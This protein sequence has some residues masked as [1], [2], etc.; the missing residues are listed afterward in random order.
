MGLLAT[1]IFTTSALGQNTASISLGWSPSPDPAVVGYNLYSGAASQTYTNLVSVGNVTNAVMGSLVPGTAYYFST[2][3]RDAQGN[4]SPFSN[5]IS[6]TVPMSAS[7]TPTNTP[8]TISSI[9][10]QSINANSATPPLSF[11]VS[12]SETAAANL[13]VSAS[14]SNPALVPNSGLMLTN[15]GT[16]WTVR[17]TP[18]VGQVGTAL[19]ALTG[20]DPSLCT[21]TTFQ[22]TVNP[23][24]A[25]VLS[26]PLNGTSFTAPATVSLSAN[27]T[28]NGHTITQVQFFNGNTLL[29]SATT[30]PYVLSWNSVPAGS[31]SVSASAVFDAGSG[32]VT[33][34]GSLINVAPAP[35]LTPPWQTTGIGTIIPTSNAGITNGL[36]TVQSSGN[37]TS[38]SDNFLFLYQSLSG[39]GSIVARVSS[40]QNVASWT[41]AGVMMR[42]SLSAGAKN[43]FMLVSAAKGLA[44]Q[45]RTS[46]NGSTT[47]TIVSGAA[48]YWVKVTRSGSTF[49]AYVST[50]GSAWKLVGSQSITMASTISVGLVVGSHVDGTV[51]TAKFDHV[52][53]DSGSTT[54]ASLPAGWSTRD[55]GAIAA[56]GDADY[57]S[58]TYTVKGSGDDI[59]GTADA[60]RFVYHQLTGDGSIVARVASLQ[61]VEAW[62]KAGVMMR[63][64]LDAGSKHVSMI[65]SG[66]KGLAYQRRLHTNGESVSASAGAGTAPFW[67]KVQRIGNTFSGFISSNGS[68]W[69]QIASDSIL[70]TSTIYVGLAVT[71]HHD[72]ALATARFDGVK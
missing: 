6:Y 71:S 21:T 15:N 8:P 46:T 5:E 28:A 65:V 60:F 23:L 26:A 55:V 70:M 32:L 69:K 48:P 20:C 50:D 52:S 44:F 61:A 45:R 62:T 1:V 16:N 38:S 29:G 63:E 2:R 58:G 12:D 64:T 67:V 40:V 57:A 22:L 31:Y 25:I 4:E 10:N 41:K 17:I 53:I 3:A 66:A 59:W 39:D 68:T 56:A 35:G 11:T 51:A 30:P 14:P 19:I 27:V 33:S 36:Y 7:S 42:E 43:A 47:S 24:P 9:P 37:L 13:A 49:S 34:G 54:T 18:A 72:G